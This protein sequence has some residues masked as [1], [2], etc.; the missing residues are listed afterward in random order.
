MK[1]HYTH[2]ELSIIICY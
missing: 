2:A 1:T